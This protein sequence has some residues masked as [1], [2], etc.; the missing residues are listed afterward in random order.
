M[1]GFEKFP[2][3]FPIKQGYFILSSLRYSLL[4]Y[5]KQARLKKKKD[6]EHIESK[7]QFSLCTMLLS[8]VSSH[9]LLI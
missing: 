6:V 8:L 4:S 2:E 9:P 5:I 1:N 3:S 7:N